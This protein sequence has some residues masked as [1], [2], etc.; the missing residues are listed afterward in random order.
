MLIVTNAGRA[1]NAL[2]CL[3]SMVIWYAQGVSQHQVAKGLDV[4]RSTWQA[5]RLYQDR[6]DA[7]PAVVAFFHSVPGV[8]PACIA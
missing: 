6:L 8:S 1:S 5:W 7:C 4:P 3:R 2:T